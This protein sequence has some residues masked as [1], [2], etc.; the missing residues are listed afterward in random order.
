M[1]VIHGSSFSNPYMTLFIHLS[2]SSPH[3][4][5]SYSDL[6]TR[7]VTF[8]YFVFP[9]P[10]LR[11]DFRRFWGSIYGYIWKNLA[12][13]GCEITVFI[14]TLLMK[15]MVVHPALEGCRGYHTRLSDFAPKSA[16]TQKC[17]GGARRTGGEALVNPRTRF[18][19]RPP[20]RQP[21]CGATY[22]HFW[23]ER[24]ARFWKVYYWSSPD[25]PLI[26]GFLQTGLPEC[27]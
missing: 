24:F 23:I 11:H 27:R 25:L 17:L 18:W 19:S 6:Y 15:I 7:T 22:W 13:Q 16:I 20:N 4:W 2:Q 26:W 9:F 5:L 10:V 12:P 14:Y 21:T 3:T 8:E 1:S